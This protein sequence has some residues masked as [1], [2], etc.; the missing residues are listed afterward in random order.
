MIFIGNTSDLFYTDFSLLS[1]A[2]CY[3]V[4]SVDG[5]GNESLTGDTVCVENCPIYE[6]PN[7]FTPNGDGQNDLYT[8]RMPY[9]FIESVEFRIYHSWGNLVFETTDPDINWDGSV[10]SGAEASEGVYLYEGKAYV[11]TTSGLQAIDL[12]L[13]AG[14]GG[15]IHLIRSQ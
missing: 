2:R 1:F 11:R 4:T 5:F 15:F 7:T 8:P 13:G 12:P 14:N 10:L 3:V 6:L 9:R